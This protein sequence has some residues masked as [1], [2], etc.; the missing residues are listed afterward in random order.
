MYVLLLIC[1]QANSEYKGSFT[2]TLPHTLYCFL[3]VDF[4]WIIAL[5]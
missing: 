1:A 4:A 5:W 3:M 2:E